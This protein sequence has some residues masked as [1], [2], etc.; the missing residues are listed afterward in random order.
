M[1]GLALRRRL[2]AAIRPRPVG[3]QSRNVRLTHLSAAF[4]SFGSLFPPLQRGGHA[5]SACSTRF[6]AP[7]HVQYL[8]VFPLHEPRAMLVF[9][10]RD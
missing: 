7:T 1:V 8:E 10:P 6:T 2:R 9:R 4:R 5:R 3:V